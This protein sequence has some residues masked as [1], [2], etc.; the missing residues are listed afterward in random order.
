[1]NQLDRDRLFELMIFY[2]DLT[3]WVKDDKSE[4]PNKDKNKI[5]IIND[6]I[7]AMMVQYRKVE[8]VKAMQ[9]LS[10]EA[11]KYKFAILPIDQETEVTGTMESVVL[12]NA[13]ERVLK[14]QTNCE[15]CSRCDYKYCEWY[16][17]QKFLGKQGNYKKK[18]CPYKT[19]LNDIFED[20]C[21][22]L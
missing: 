8:G 2:D 16:A 14:T 15:C 3:Q 13:I 12:K 7:I 18:Q 20:L 10:E 11:K 21:E 4:L 17:L 22:K 19:D 9:S 1:M 5:K 6:N